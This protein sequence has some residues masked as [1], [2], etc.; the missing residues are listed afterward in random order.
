MRA[1]KPFIA[2][3]SIT[4]P[5]KEQWQV[6]F[7]LFIENKALS[8]GEFF[9]LES[10]QWVAHGFDSS[11]INWDAVGQAAIG[12]AVGG[13]LGSGGGIWQT[14]NNA[15]LLETVGVNVG[16][17]VT[18]GLVSSLVMGENYHMTEFGRDLGLGSL[19]GVHYYRNE[20]NVGLPETLKEANA[21]DGVNVAANHHRLRGEVG[22][23]KRVFSDG[24]EAVYN[25]AMELVTNPLNM[26]T[27]NYV[28]PGNWRSLS[29]VMKNIG[30]FATDMLPYYYFGNTMYDGAWLHERVT[31]YSPG[32]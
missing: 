21:Q 1:E 30:H 16:N 3:I 28:N 32:Y 24:R 12:G 19:Q 7:N 11:K 17:Q 26:G 6:I 2:D 18:E 10:A 20:L 15:G 23:V 13:V 14:G 22:N 25:S 8:Y 31:G 27:F 9:F 5:T 4:Q 29:G